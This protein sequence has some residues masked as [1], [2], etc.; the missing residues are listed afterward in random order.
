M[1]AFGRGRSRAGETTWTVEVRTVNSRHLDLNLR[2]PRGLNGLEDRMTKLIGDRLGRGRVD[3]FMSVSGLPP[4]GQRLTLNRPLVKEYLAV[5]RELREELGLDRPL[6]LEPF[7][8]NRDLVMSEEQAPDYE[9]LWRQCE[10]ALIK[11]LDEVDAMRAVEGESMGRD[12]AVRLDRLG[13]LFSQAAARSPEIVEAYRQRLNERIAQLLDR[14][15][16]DPQRLAQ[17][18]AIIADKCDVT[19]E[20]V[21]A[22]SHL[23]QFRAFLQEGGRV[24][25]KLD[26]L[27]Q[28]LNREANTLGSKS[29]DAEAGQLVVEIKAELERVREQVQNIE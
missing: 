6:G 19:E 24:G 11:A 15:E 18:V 5:L 16:P 17:E 27:I 9:E 22:S 1:T 23:D 2:L 8:A 29:P 13:E 25:R 20:A 14:G 7:L 3:L 10:P 28:E 21:R 12:L 4:F 26:F